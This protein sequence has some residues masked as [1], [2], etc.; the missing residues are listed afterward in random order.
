MLQKYQQIHFLVHGH[1][2]SSIFGLHLL[3]AQRLCNFFLKILDHGSWTR[4]WTMNQTMGK[5]LS[6]MVGLHGPWCKLT[7][8]GCFHVVMNAWSWV[9]LHNNPRP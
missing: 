8:S 9:V 3:K 7:L 2:S 1:S 6:S 5:R 4:G